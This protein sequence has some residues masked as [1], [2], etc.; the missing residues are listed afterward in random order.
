[1][2]SR[3]QPELSE[4]PTMA[5]LRGAKNSRSRCGVTRRREAW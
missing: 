4:A 3:A 5:T 1:M 2:I